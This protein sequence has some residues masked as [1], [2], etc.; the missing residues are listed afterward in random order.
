MSPAYHHTKKVA[1]TM[2]AAAAPAVMEAAQPQFELGIHG[3]GGASS[4]AVY[5]YGQ[6]HGWAELDNGDRETVPAMLV[7]KVCLVEAEPPG[8]APEAAT[9]LPVYTLSFAN[10]EGVDR[11][12]KAFES[13]GVRIELGDTM[14]MVAE[15]AL[16]LAI[17]HLSNDSLKDSWHIAGLS[18]SYLS[19]GPRA[20]A[21][22]PSGRGSSTSR[23][24][25][26]RTAGPPAT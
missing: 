25:S 13:L 5:D 2:A 24:R 21:S 7:R 10:P 4:L 22:A 12:G 20:T 3:N 9:R 19:S 8:A 6:G 15:R 26:T 14:K 23:S 17:R 11:A 16:I 1:A 18:R